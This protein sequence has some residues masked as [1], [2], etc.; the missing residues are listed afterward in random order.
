MKY[1]M[2]ALILAYQRLVSPW[3]PAGCIF[4]PSC[5]S[6]ALEAYRKYGFWRGTWLA[7]RRLLRC[8]PWFTGGY[9]P[10]P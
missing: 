1:V 9:D 6:F 7:Q 5:A 3:L 8:W 2:I 10:V 4:R